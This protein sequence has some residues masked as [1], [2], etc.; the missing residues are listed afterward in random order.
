MAATLATLTAGVSSLILKF[1]T[2]Y[3]QIRTTDIRDDLAKVRVWCSTSSGFTPSDANKV[4]DGLS[5]SIVIGKLTDGTALLP[6][7]D[8]YVKYAFI[9]D[10]EDTQ[11]TVQSL[12]AVKPILATAQTV[13]I[14]GYTAFS[15]NNT[16]TAYTPTT[17]TLTAVINGITSPVYAWT[18]TGG[19]LSSSTASSTVVTPSLSATSVSVTLSVTGAAVTTPI[20]KTI[21]MAVVNDATPPPKYATAYLYQWVTTTPSTPT[22]STTYIWSSGSNSSYTT[23]DGWSTTVPTNPG[24]AL[25]KLWTATKSV[26]DVAA[27]TS[28]TINW[29][30][31]ATISAVSQNGAFGTNGTNGSNGSNGSNGANGINSVTVRVYKTGLTIPAGPTGTSTYTWS[32]ASFTAPSGWTLAPPTDTSGLLGQTLWAATVTLT[33]SAT[34]ATTT[35]NWTTAAIVAQSYYGTNGSNGTNGNNGTNGS[36]G[37]SARVAYAV[38]TTTPSSTPA[39]LTVAGDTLPTTGTWFPGITW[40]SNSPASLTA[41]QFLYQVDGLYNPVT[42]QTNWIGVPYLSNLKVGNLAAISIN[43]GAL[44]VTDTITVTG[45][46]TDGVLIKTDGIYIYN[47]G[48]LRVKLGSI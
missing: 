45:N 22:G 47:A 44:T 33:D 19:T 11:Y 1:D 38:T 28:T 26:T 25:V 14:S 30:S 46:G 36:Q 7:T 3:D 15:K 23:S 16:G 21:T 20:V 2:P 5:L 8:Y 40:Q 24:T 12:A 34:N 10:I 31:G 41:G 18:I 17:A 32:S 48:V 29:T 39:N 37:A 35:I 6:G 9:S 42:N 13:D 4:F 43:T 27:A